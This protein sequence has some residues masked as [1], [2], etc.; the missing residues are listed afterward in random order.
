MTYA[1]LI[2]EILSLRDLPTVDTVAVGQSTTGQ[3]IYGYHI[4]NYTGPQILIEAGIHAREYPSTLTVVGMAK[5]LATQDITNGGVYIVP[6]VNPD[7]VRLV[8]DGLDWITCAKTR[9]YLLSI[10]DGS[11]DF[12]Q[13]KADIWAV[14]LNVNF[15]ALWGGG[16]QNVFCPSPANWVGYYPASEREVRVLMDLTANIR[17]DLTLSYH[18]KGNVIYYG[19]EVLTPEEISRDKE[20]A[21]IISSINGYIPIKTE[22]STGGYSDWVSETYRIP[23]FTVEV[24]D[25]TLPT[26]IPLSA[27]PDA[28]LRNQAVPQAMLDY[29]NTVNQPRQ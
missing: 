7:G 1:E 13:W 29:L 25:S 24:G 18:T 17:P 5:Y 21:D 4:G 9:E 23:A 28:I 26:P 16:S 22:N 11:T 8:L 12:S 3:E 27:I 14:D 19:F 10:N 15:P 6:L 2:A 20:I